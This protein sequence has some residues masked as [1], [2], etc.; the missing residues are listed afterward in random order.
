MFHDGLEGMDI[1][2]LSLVNAGSF[3]PLDDYLS[4]F[5][6][7]LVASAG[8]FADRPFW[9][10]VWRTTWMPGAVWAYSPVHW[11]SAVTQALAEASS[12]RITPLWD[13]PQWRVQY[14]HPPLLKAVTSPTGLPYWQRIV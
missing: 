4:R 1:D 3:T 7:V 11:R 12:I 9:E 10:I 2:G 6:V 13:R 5:D 14:Q 8:D